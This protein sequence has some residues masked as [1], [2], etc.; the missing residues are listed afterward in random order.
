MKDIYVFGTGRG[1]DIL[2][3]FLLKEK[4]RIISYIDNN[5]SKQ[6]KYRDNSK[7]ISPDKIQSN[8]DVIILTMKNYK[9]VKEQLAGYGVPEDKIVSMYDNE[10]LSKEAASEIFKSKDLSSF[11]FQQKY[12]SLEK[13]NKCYVWDSNGCQA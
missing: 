11:I 3:S 8:F 1:A 12:N 5:I 13:K 6:G 9:S 10:D 4:V 2:E 7:I